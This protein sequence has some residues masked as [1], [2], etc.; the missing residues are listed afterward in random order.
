MYMSL[1]CSVVTVSHWPNSVGFGLVLGKTLVSVGFVFLTSTK[2]S[3]GRLVITRTPAVYFVPH[4][5]T[6]AQMP[7][8]HRLCGWSVDGTLLNADREIK[9]ERGQDRPTVPAND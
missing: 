9:G 4:G 3:C 1:Q 2:T 7:A 5:Q 6:L 8:E